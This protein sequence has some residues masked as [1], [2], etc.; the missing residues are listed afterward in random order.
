MVS[1]RFQFPVLTD[2]FWW[3]VK[4]HIVTNNC[5]I[6]QIS[7]TLN[8]FQLE[9]GQNALVTS[10]NRCTCWV[11]VPSIAWGVSALR[12]L[13][14]GM[15]ISGRDT[16]HIQGSFVSLFTSALLL[17]TEIRSHSRKCVVGC[18]VEHTEAGKMVTPTKLG[19]RSWLVSVS[20]RYNNN[21][22]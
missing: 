19:F 5:H 8:F 7:K 18:M 20:K 9:S 17:L 2:H 3:Y 11:G 22:K 1:R 21:V 13:W 12:S 15:E 16:D 4:V 14:V 10:S 6:T